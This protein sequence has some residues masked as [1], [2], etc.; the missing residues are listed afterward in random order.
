MFRRTVERISFVIGGALLGAIGLYEYEKLGPKLPAPL[1]TLKPPLTSIVPEFPW[2]GWRDTAINDLFERDAYIT[3]YN[4]R[5]RHPNWVLEHLTEES[6]KRGEGVDRSK[7]RFLEDLDIPEKFR[8]RLAD[9]V[10]SGYDRG[11]MAPASDAKFSQV[12]MDQTFLLTNIAP[13]VGNGFNRDYWAHFEEF[14]RRLIYKEGFENVYV[15]TGPAY[16][17]KKENDKWYVKYEMIGSIAVPTHFYKVILADR[18]DRDDP[19][20]RFYALG[21]FLMPNERISDTTPLQVYNVTLDS[22][23]RTTGLTF[24]NQDIV[25][26]SVPLCSVEASK[27]II[28]ANPKHIKEELRSV[29]PEPLKDKSETKV[30]I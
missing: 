10:K 9:Y 29:L 3:S 30:N 8:A 16:L 5:L 14:C 18:A 15:F 11:H 12:A 27:C 25:D 13:Q 1:P 20:K 17:P 7:S 2:T 24:L 4:R 26:K 6:L 22:L 23:E 19:K 28:V 21:A